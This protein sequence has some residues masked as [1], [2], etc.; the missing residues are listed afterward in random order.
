MDYLDHLEAEAIY[1]LREVAGQFEKPALLFSGGK[2]SITLVHLAKKAF[3]PGKFPFPLVHIDT[4]HNF[5]ETITFRDSL[6][7][8]IGEKLIVG[9]VQDSIDQ[10]KVVEQKGKNASR[11]ALQTVTLLDTIAKHGFD[12]C[13]GG[14]RRDEE[15]AR[16]KER[17]FSVRDEFGQWDPKRQ[18]PELWSIFNGKINKGENVRVFPI[19][20]WT[21]LDVWNYI[22]R[23]QIALPSIYFSHERDVITRNGQLMAAASFLNIDADD[24]IERKSVRFR[25]VGDMTCTAAV[26]STATELDDIIAE[27]KASTVSERGARMDDK[28]SE[29]AMEERKKQ[30]YF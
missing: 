22:K 28:V 30:G 12:A 20:N 3:R 21:E 16:A 14:A 29:A 5:P 10:G 11:N 9:Y 18:R 6:I 1:I 2:D 24:I 23:E 26:D 4:G 7:E 25:T 13:I 15:K 27:I 17:I 19:S 8:D